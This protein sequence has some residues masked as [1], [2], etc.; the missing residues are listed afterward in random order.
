[1]LKYI[2]RRFINPVAK[3]ICVK[4]KELSPVEQANLEI[5]DAWYEKYYSS[6]VVTSTLIF[7]SLYISD[8]EK[9]KMDSLPAHI[10][11]A[12]LYLISAI[13]D[14]YSTIQ[15][16]KANQKAIELGLGSQTYE[17]NILAGNA[18]TPDEYINNKKLL[19]AQGI[20]MTIAT[21]FPPVG[22]AFAGAKSVCTANNFRQAKRINRAI[23][24]AQDI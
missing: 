14:R 10:T 13:A 24:I 8:S 17:E 1:M 22:I 18:K 16:L 11:A 19:I 9:I 15:G 4:N 21:A 6:Y 3:I 5:P 20:V 2:V 12:T 7:L 23:E